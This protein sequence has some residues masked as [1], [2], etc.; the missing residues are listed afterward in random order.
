MK[1][2]STD[3]EHGLEE[4]IVEFG[5]PLVLTDAFQLSGGRYG[6]HSE[7]NGGIRIAGE[8]PWP[9]FFR[10]PGKQFYLPDRT[11]LLEPLLQTKWVFG[12]KKLFYLWNDSTAW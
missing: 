7:Q 8:L 6:G 10:K 4:E 2:F 5:G 11:V 12:C 3:G 9:S 1:T